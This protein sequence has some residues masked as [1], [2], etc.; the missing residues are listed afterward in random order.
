MQSPTIIRAQSLLK[1]LEASC[2][3]YYFSEQQPCGLSITYLGYFVFKSVF[4]LTQNSTKSK[5]TII[6]IPKEKV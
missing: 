3:K 6:Q 2:R 5:Q 4:P 1:N